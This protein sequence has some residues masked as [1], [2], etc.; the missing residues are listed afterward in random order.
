MTRWRRWSTENWARNWNSTIRTYYICTNQDLS[1]RMRRTKFSGI[2]RY[3]WIPKSQSEDQTKWQQKKTKNKKK[4]NKKN[5]ENL[6]NNELCCPNGANIEKSKKMKR[7]QYIY[8]ARELEKQ[9]KKKTKK[10]KKQSNMKVTVI[11]IVIGALGT[12]LQGFSFRY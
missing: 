8:L 2:L 11:P 1:R 5:K 9:N 3:K 12:I 7:D 10:K 4:K 6:P